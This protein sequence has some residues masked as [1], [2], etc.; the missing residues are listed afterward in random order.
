MDSRAGDVKSLNNWVEK[1]TVL[2]S[3]KVVR[4]LNMSTGPVEI[5]E[6]VLKAQL[7]SFMTPH[8]N[9]FWKLHDETL[10]LLK[11]LLRTEG[12]V[13]AFHGSIRAGLDVAL[14]NL[15]RPGMK[16]LAITNGYWG[17]LVG[18]NAKTYGAE[19]TW[20]RESLLR[21][22][23]PEVVRKAL[24]KD[25]EIELV[26]VIHV[27]TNA[28]ILNP[29]DEIG[30]IVC[31]HEALYFVDTACSA[32]SIPLETD[33]WGIDIGVTGSHKCL[34]AVPGLAVLT[35]NDRAWKR[36]QSN[37]DKVRRGYFN[38]VNLFEKTIVRSETPPYTQPS[39]LFR[40]L[41]ASL[42][43]I[44]EIGHESWFALH[45]DMAALFR[46]EIREAGFRMLTDG[47]G[48][49][50]ALPDHHLSD[51]VMAV[52]YPEGVDDHRL[53]KTLYEDYGIFV[54]GNI[55]EFLGRS[56]RL[57]LMSPP[58]LEPRNVLGS[59]AAI[60]RAMDQSEN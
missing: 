38:L 48:G 16:V 34:C 3:I 30:A 39:S 43:E 7:E 24:Q 29:I 33:T 46:E 31:E 56:F 12:D 18:D 11:S 13:L 17:D 22:I 6:R 60:K 58:Q 51:T 59:I 47:I 54:I 37:A 23:D 26:T 45:R 53:R 15:V 8:C 50:E 20:V 49:K 21:P 41:N 42:I 5:S 57:G 52:A 2:R 14:S 32:G 44:A 27:E 40:A 36:I 35:L 55:G 28:G 4:P 25:P 10:L 19:V 1:N 9:D